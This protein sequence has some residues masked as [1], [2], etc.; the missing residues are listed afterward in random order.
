MVRQAVER[1]P[2]ITAFLKKINEKSESGSV[3]KA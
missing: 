2:I 3:L 1:E